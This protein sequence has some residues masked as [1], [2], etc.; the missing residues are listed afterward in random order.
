MTRTFKINGTLYT[1]EQLVA[2]ANK[3]A[4]ELKRV[5]LQGSTNE[6]IVVAIDH[7]TCYAVSPRTNAVIHGWCG[8]FVAN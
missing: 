5:S 6:L 1:G 8:D 3:H 4:H 7:G 2:Y